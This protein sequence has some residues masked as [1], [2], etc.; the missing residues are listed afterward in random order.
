MCYDKVLIITL[1]RLYA[2]CECEHL[3]GLAPT[4]FISSLQNKKYI[5]HELNSFQAIPGPSTHKL[6]QEIDCLASI[7]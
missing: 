4:I 2:S 3:T 1:H 5:N 7:S 6:C